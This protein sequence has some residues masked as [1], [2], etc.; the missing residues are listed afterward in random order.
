MAI[1]YDEV[2]GVM[3][4]THTGLDDSSSLPLT[5][6]ESGSAWDKVMLPLGTRYRYFNTKHASMESVK[7]FVTKHFIVSGYLSGFFSRIQYNLGLHFLKAISGT[8]FHK[9][10]HEF[11]FVLVFCIRLLR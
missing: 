10:C 11:L 1:L 5:G 2:I 9:I 8:Q 4:R 7:T 3:V 6:P